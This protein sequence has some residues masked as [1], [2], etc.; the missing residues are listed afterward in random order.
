MDSGVVSTLPH[1]VGGGCKAD[2]EITKP[3]NTDKDNNVDKDYNINDGTDC[4][5]GDEIFAP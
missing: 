2:I 3:C 4:E 5:Y 1:F